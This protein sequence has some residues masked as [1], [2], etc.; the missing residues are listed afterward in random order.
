MNF[1]ATWS[2][3]LR[4]CSLPIDT[5][6]LTAQ[7]VLQVMKH[8]IFKFL[9]ALYLLTMAYSLY[10]NILVSVEDRSSAGA[11]TQFPL[12]LIPIIGSTVGFAVARSWGGFKSRLGKAI[13]FYSLGLL[14][15]GCG[16]VG[17]LIYIYI[18]GRTEVP[19]PSPADFVYMLAQIMW[20]TGSLLIAGVIGAQYAIKSRYGWVK[21]VLA[22]VLA[23]GL[24][25]LL[26]VT[27]ARQGSLES[28]GLSMQTFFDFYYPIA[29]AL[30][31]TLVTVV[32]LLSRK[33][34]GG[35]YKKSI[36]VLFVGFIFQFFGDFTYTWTTTIEVYHNGH[37][38][39]MLF[40]TAMLTL[41]WGLLLFDAKRID[42]GTKRVK[43][44]V[45]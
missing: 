13:I 2:S 24:S 1:T 20:Y 38:A 17:W 10:L 43:D 31:L 32:Y 35:L 12:A 44:E 19:Y 40:T 36:I 30:S 34:L 3:M 4:P 45:A 22:S 16:V 21:A 25:Y 41:T 29:T 18:L 7:N 39:D 37:W 23:V 42:T 11:I 26:L 6:G 14:A 28:T 27:V 33:Y 8:K 15:W 9:V 5:S